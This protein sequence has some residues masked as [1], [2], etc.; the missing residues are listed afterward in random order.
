MACSYDEGYSSADAYGYADLPV[1]TSNTVK[2]VFEHLGCPAHAR[3]L[4]GALGR[5]A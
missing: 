2:M 5:S 1:L 3:G 4:V